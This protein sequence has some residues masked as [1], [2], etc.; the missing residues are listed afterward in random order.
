MITVIGLKGE[1]QKVTNV[2][3][4]QQKLV[5]KGKPMKDTDQI[6]TY[7]L[8]DN[9]VITEIKIGNVVSSIGGNRILLLAWEA[10]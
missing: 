1:I 5:I 2:T 6:S 3:V 10:I 8:D 4:S 9:R 7:D